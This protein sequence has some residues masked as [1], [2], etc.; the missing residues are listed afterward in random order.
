MNTE[1]TIGHKVLFRIS[2]YCIIVERGVDFTKPDFSTFW[3]TNR[4][5]NTPKYCPSG[6]QT[7]KV[8]PKVHLVPQK[9]AS[10]RFFF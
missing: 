8:S 2:K 3:A 5:T 10:E 9:G 6:R 4:Q 1:Y 7:D